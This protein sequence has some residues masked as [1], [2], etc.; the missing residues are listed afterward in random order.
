MVADNT[1][2]VL[3]AQDDTLLRKYNTKKAKEKHGDG[4]PKAIGDLFGDMFGK[5]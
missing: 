3:E 2:K 4:Q 5:K 1:L